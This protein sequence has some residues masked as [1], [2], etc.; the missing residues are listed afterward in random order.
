MARN[1]GKEKNLLTRSRMK[2]AENRKVIHLLLRRKTSIGTIV[3]FWKKK[4]TD[5]F[6][7]MGKILTLPSNVLI[8]SRK[9]TPRQSKEFISSSKKELKSG[10]SRKKERALK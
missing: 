8:I 7:L 2:S 3:K 5:T 6:K 9:R 10:V 4:S 1:S